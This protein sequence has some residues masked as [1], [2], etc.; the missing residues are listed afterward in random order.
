MHGCFL[1]VAESDLESE[2]VCSFPEE[3]LACFAG[4]SLVYPRG[5]NVRPNPRTRHEPDTGFFG[6]RLDLNGF[7]L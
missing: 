4:I 3:E 1:I 7:G 5:V 2:S 6:L